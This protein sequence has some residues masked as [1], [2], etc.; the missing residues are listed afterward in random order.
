MISTQTHTSITV[1]NFQLREDSI[2]YN[3]LILNLTSII[4]K[5]NTKIFKYIAKGLKKSKSVPLIVQF[6]LV[7][8]TIT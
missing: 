5:K 8:L 3:L 6:E 1:T 4:E 2:L 7:S